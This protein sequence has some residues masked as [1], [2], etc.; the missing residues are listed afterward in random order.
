MGLKR[1]W[2]I[3]MIE[4]AIWDS[5]V[6]CSGWFGFSGQGLGFSRLKG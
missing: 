6:C 1:V 2:D 4:H 5:G 3:G